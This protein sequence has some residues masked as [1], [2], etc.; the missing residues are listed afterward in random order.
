MHTKNDVRLR[1][2]TALMAVCFL[3]AC[4]TTRITIEEEGSVRKTAVATTSLFDSTSQL[5]RLALI[6]NTN[7]TSATLGSHST[8]TSSEIVSRLREALKQLP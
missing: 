7:G 1:T 5:G 3:A 2:Q 8:S 4:S 6:A